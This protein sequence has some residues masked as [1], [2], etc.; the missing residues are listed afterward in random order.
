M[1]G[2]QRNRLFTRNNFLLISWCFFFLLFL[3]QKLETQ[4]KFKRISLTNLVREKKDGDKN[5]KDRRQR[6]QYPLLENV[7]DDNMTLSLSL[8]LSL[9]IYICEKT[10]ESLS[11]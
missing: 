9:Y 2:I 10:R 7:D 4:V 3:T 1:T 11:F 6:T 5:E 8:S